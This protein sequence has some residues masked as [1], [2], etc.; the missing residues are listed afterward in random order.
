MLPFYHTLLLVHTPHMYMPTTNKI[1][2]YGYLR[3]GPTKFCGFQWEREKE[4][5]G[6]WAF[7]SPILKIKK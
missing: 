5:D 4:R 2:A 1:K 3:C 6:I 7:I